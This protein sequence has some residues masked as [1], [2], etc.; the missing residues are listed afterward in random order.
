MIIR[1]KTLITALSLILISC[2]AK[3]NKLDIETVTE[4]QLYS[5]GIKKTKAANYHDAIKIFTKFEEKY[6]TSIHYAD[7]LVLKA[8]SFYS[9]DKHTD[10]I[11]TIDDF[12]QQFPVH[13]DV[14]YM[15]YLK[16]MS[17]Y[18][19]IMDIGRDQSFAML[20]KEGFETLINLYPHSKYASDAKRKLEYINNMLAGKEMDIGRFYLRTN[21]HVFSINRFKN[22]IENYQTN[23]FIPE[24]LYRLTEVYFIL[25]VKEE[26]EKYV[27]VLAHNYP[28]SIWYNKA[29]NLLIHNDENKKSSS[30]KQTSQPS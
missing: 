7:I 23:I 27:S 18:K 10:A 21:K 11:L 8:Y 12:L 14:D 28:K 5:E 22:V 9:E 17:N 4:N 29:Y 26:A 13:K 15:H 16:S 2:S 20:A 30:S 3:N 1:N 24:A 25:G 6:P 19:Q